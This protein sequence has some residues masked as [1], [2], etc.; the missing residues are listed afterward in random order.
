MR[1]CG[2]AE[3]WSGPMAVPGYRDARVPP[4]DPAA[5]VDLAEAEEFLRLCYAENPGLGPVLPRLIQIR[6]QIATTGTY[7]HTGPELC[8]APG[9]RGATPAGASAGCTGVACS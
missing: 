6:A 1:R 9:W 2:D 8:S 4:W 7:V 3:G 5:P